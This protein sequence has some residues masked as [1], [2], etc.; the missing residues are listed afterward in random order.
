MPTG[1]SPVSAPTAPYEVSTPSNPPDVL[2]AFLK[3]CRVEC[4]YARWWRLTA[5]WG[6]SFTKAGPGFVAVLDGAC[7]LRLEGSAFETA[8]RAND[9]ALFTRTTALTL[10]D[11][12]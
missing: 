10:C 7:L 4:R 3:P 11:R 8:L 9:F 1:M 5:P 12:P 2:S 6:L